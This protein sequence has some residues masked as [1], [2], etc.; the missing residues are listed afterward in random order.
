MANRDEDAYSNRLNGPS[1]GI[2]SCTI[3]E[4]PDRIRIRQ[5]SAIQHLNLTFKTHLIALLHPNG[6]VNP[7]PK[8]SII[9]KLDI[10]ALLSAGFIG[11]RCV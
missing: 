11:V 9:M 2:S 4:P 1:D 8:R 5:K 10:L 3:P 7:R 6:Q